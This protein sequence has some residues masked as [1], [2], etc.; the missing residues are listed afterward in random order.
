MVAIRTFIEHLQKKIDFSR[1]FQ[2]DFIHNFNIF[3]REVIYNRKVCYVV[4]LSAEHQSHGP[5]NRPRKIWAAL[6]LHIL[7]PGLGQFYNGRF[8][9]AALFFLLLEFIYLGGGVLTYLSESFAVFITAILLY[10]AF[11]V[12]ILVDAI[13]ITFRNRQQFIPTK[14]TDAWYKYVAFILI[15]I[16]ISGVNG[17]FRDDVL[18]DS[19]V[20]PSV[21]MNDTFM[22]GDIVETKKCGYNSIE[23]GDVVVFQFPLDTHQNYIKRCVAKGGQTVEI[24]DKKLY[25]DGDFIPLPGLAK[26]SDNKIY[27]YADS[28]LRGKL[29]NMPE[30]LVPEGSLFALGDNRDNSYDSRHFGFV[31]GQYIIGRPMFII[32]SFEPDK[33]QLKVTHIKTG[34]KLKIL[35]QYF[36]HIGERTR[37]DRIGRRVE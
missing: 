17:V 1:R 27:P 2:V 14:F 10:I 8:K 22:T 31:R 12:F 21:S 29:D 3:I 9:Q 24:I 30:K 6:L 28:T 15:A 7:T 37:W 5:I 32:W 4:E 19:H 33:R 36:L 34:N 11:W 18:F 26:N 35:F 25:V 13:R 20:I 16:V 23:T